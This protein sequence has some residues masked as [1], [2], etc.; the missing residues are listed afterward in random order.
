MSAN[1]ENAGLGP[2]ALALQLIYANRSVLFAGTISA[3]EIKPL[4]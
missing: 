3:E 2:I 1:A 4:C